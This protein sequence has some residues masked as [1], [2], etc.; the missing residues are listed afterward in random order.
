[1]RIKNSAFQLES[2]FDHDADR[3][4]VDALRAAVVE[5]IHALYSRFPT[6]F[7]AVTADE[8][9]TALYMEMREKY[10]RILHY[11]VFS[12]PGKRKLA[13]ELIWKW[14]EA[15]GKYVG[16]QFWSVGAKAVFDQEVISAGGWPITARIAR[17]L[18]LKLSAKSR[19]NVIKLTHEHVYPIKDMKSLLASR[20]PLTREEIR[21]QLERQCMSCVLLESEH[22]RSAGHDSNP[23]LRYTNAGNIRLADNPAW[24]NSQ[25]KAIIQAGLL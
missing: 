13:N 9:D 21:E 20:Y 5:D 6:S 22:D 24:L 15:T 4:V 12:L 3:N 10:H 25:R 7:G 14:T 23:W 16:C 17:T 11:G 1:V 2:V 18:E 19:P 8:L